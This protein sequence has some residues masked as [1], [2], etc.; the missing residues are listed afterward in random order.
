MSEL[1]IDCDDCMKRL[2]AGATVMVVRILGNF[3]RLDD[4]RRLDDPKAQLQLDM[5]RELI[6]VIEDNEERARHLLAD[7]V[8]AGAQKLLTDAAGGDQR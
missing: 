6:S 3:K 5:L 4:G 2:A 1:H 7:E 8:V